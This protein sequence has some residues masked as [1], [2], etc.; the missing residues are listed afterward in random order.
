MT[1]VRIG[2][3]TERLGNG[4]TEIRR[5]TVHVNDV[6]LHVMEAG[7]PGDPLIIL[8][9][10]FPEGAY[11]WRHQLPVLANAGYHVMAPDQRGYGR[12]SVPADVEAY[13]IRELTGDLNALVTEAGH[14]DAIFVGH[15]WG[16]IIVWENARLNPERV[17]AVV[18]VSVP[19]VEWPGP[20]TTLFKMVYEDNFFYMLYFQPVG[21]A[22]TE[23]G[24][25][26]YDTVKNVFW[27]ASGEG[28][29]MPTEL[30]K[31]EGTGFLTNMPTPPALPWP[32][33]TEA[34]LEYFG[35]QFSR[36]GFFGPVSYYRNLDANYEILKDLPL[37][38]I[39]MP[40]FFIGGTQDAVA[41]MD[42][43]GV[44]RMQTQLPDFRG[45]VMLDGC[46][47]WTQQERPEQFNEALLGFLATL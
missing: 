10:G 41:V 40:S 27:G 16:S 18:G 33:F 39:T 12:S 9:H 21:P 43:T 34:D 42:P 32:W 22:E 17:R 4:D 13:G 11:S 14:D 26:P 24:A 8:S 6:D 23:L 28:F 46:G 2:G 38:R 36:S 5:R 44:E 31:M 45:H 7:R 19:A 15:D 1:S 29:S 35:D 3:M 25:D 30:S 20:P 47:H 37:S